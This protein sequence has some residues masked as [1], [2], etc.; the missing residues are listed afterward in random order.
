[1]SRPLRPAPLI[2]SSIVALLVLTLAQ[3]GWA[4]ERYAVTGMVVA[5]DSPGRTF[6]ASIEKIPGFMEAMTMS[7][8]VL[9]A[10]EL[11]GVVP[12][13]IIEFTLVVAKNS[14]YAESIRIRRYQGLEQDPLS[15]RRLSLLKEIATGRATKA[16]AVGASVPDFSLT[17]HKHRR[18]ALSQL[19]GKVVAI[20]FMYTTCQLPDFCLRVVNHF[21][22][23]QKRFKEQLGREL[24]LLTIT[25]DPARDVPDVLDRY[26]AQ[27]KPDPNTWRFLTGTVPDVHRVLEMFGVS[28]FPNEGLM[29]HSLHTVFIDRNG[30]LVANIE[31]NQYSSDQLVDLTR[32]VLNARAALPQK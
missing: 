2:A 5:V 17:D 24:I 31:G 3:T 13:A 6:V 7:F 23:L 20:N 25:F 11:T 32:A 4:A 12:G 10:K 28:A 9:H 16:L 30:K 29:D 27:W 21:G 22:V 14:S 8:E 18:I 19:R 15:A 26:A 1:M